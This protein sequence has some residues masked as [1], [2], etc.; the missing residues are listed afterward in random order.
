M[1]NREPEKV[2][3]STN[4]DIEDWDEGDY[5]S[6]I[7]IPNKWWSLN[8]W[9]FANKIRAKVVMAMLN[10]AERAKESNERSG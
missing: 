1:E 9:K 4:S 2:Y 5:L 6:V 8:A 3:W 7:L 10:R